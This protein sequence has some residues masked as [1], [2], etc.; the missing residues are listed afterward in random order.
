[1][2][3]PE[4]LPPVRAHVRRHNGLTLTVDPIAL[5]A[6]AAAKAAGMEKPTDIPMLPETE[7]LPLRLVCLE[8]EVSLLKSRVEQLWRWMRQSDVD[9]N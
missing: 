8:A 4:S 6:L 2:T 5:A 9:P 3:E 7:D 1:M